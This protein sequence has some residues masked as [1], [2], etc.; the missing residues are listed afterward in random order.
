MTSTIFLN[1]ILCS[2]VF[3]AVVAPLMWAILTTHR[4][5]PVQVAK[6][7]PDTSARGSQRS[8][9]PPQPR[10]GGANQRQGSLTL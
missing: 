9:T 2:A 5:E 7:R 3:V 10:Y 8:R 1:I 4:G 6:A